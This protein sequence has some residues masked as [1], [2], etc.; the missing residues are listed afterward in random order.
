MRR[1]GN[2]LGDLRIALRTLLRA[3][4]FFALATLVLALGIGSVV[5]MFGFLQVTRLP[6]PLDGIDRVYSLTTVNP[7]RNQSD[8]WIPVQDLDAWAVEQTSFESLAGFTI[9]SVSLRREGAAAEHAPASRV[10]G[11]Y[12]SMLRVQP[13]LG[14][15]LTRD[16][17]RPGAAP[18]VL[19]SE[20]LW[21][22]QFGAD[23]QVLGTTVRLDG[24]AH[25]VVG[26]APVFMD[27]P[28]GT[29]L[30]YPDR[31][32]LL[33]FDLIARLQ[34]PWI[35]PLGR[36]REGVSREAAEA[37]LQAIQ[38]RRAERHRELAAEK[39]FVRHLSIA[40]TGF[41]YGRLIPVL[42]ATVLLVLALAC[43]NAAGLLLVRGAGRTHE[44]AVRRALGAGRLR[45][46]SQMLAEAV[47]IGVAAVL[48]GMTLAYVAVEVLA[49]AVPALLPT[50]P[51]WHRIRLDRDLVLVALAA[52]AVATLVAGL[53]PAL[54]ASRVSIEPLLREGSR[55]TGLR[56]AR[57][58]RWLVVAEI[59]LSSALLA[60]AG[61]VISSAAKLGRGDVGVPTSG[62]LQAR[63]ELGP[64]Y[65]Y[66]QQIRFIRNLGHRLRAI[67]GVEAATLTT[68]PPGC[69]SYWREIY[70]LLDRPQ[71][72][73]E[74]LPTATIVRVDETFFDTFRVPVK[75]G[76]ALDWND[77]VDSMRSMVVNEAMA[78]T[79]WPDGDGE[80][81][82]KLVKLLPQVPV[83]PASVVKG[84]TADVRH[85]DRLQSLGG[86][87]PTI[88]LPL[89]QWP[90]GSFSIVLR[91]AGDP[92]ALA[93][94]VRDVV[95][96]LDPEL[97][98]FAIRTLDEERKRNA[99]PLTLLGGMFAA[100]GAVAL[101]LAAAGVYGVLSYSV[102][103]GSREIAVRRALGA[104]SSAIVLT[105]VA[106]ASWQLLL[107]L[108]L[109]VVL[110]PI[111]GV[112]VGSSLG[113]Q[114]HPMGMYA[115]V[116]GALGV[117]IA[118]ALLVP[119]RRALRL[120]PST[121]LRHT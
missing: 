9:E 88:Y 84:I 62:F 76:R 67:P 18:V 82:G 40:W 37:E 109:G 51:A 28:V 110:S 15:I 118:V 7:A 94:G 87:P 52:S 99:S 61:L 101:A 49:R 107:G 12:F 73:I 72:R 93:P 23:P 16:D 115:A 108:A 106:R 53:Y 11:E 46:A 91:G 90:T 10:T 79:L 102:A 78:R 4:G 55:D 58:V 95:R 80:G 69:T 112:V 38:A 30:W 1:P 64:R 56:S 92:M 6:P 83:I 42:F 43:V 89:T 39:P 63:I 97:S 22:S 70:A 86:T 29:L 103:Q 35:H 20:R 3:P 57:L 17:A 81:L 25:T 14:R 116:A 119:L 5:V 26:V 120:E 113:D 36:L 117:C 19:L 48:V 54:R 98:V 105:V 114:H 21:R 59:A 2:F 32:N 71:G 13:L 44:A 104:P 65:D 27:L 45:L 100:F 33:N 121:A 111:M 74:Q 68:A 66:F 60:T 85:D 34:G 96:D 77:R 50:V 31:T 41:E 75:A 24:V 47:V 8:R